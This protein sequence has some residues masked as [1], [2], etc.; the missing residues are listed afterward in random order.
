[1]RNRLGILYI[2]IN[3]GMLDENEEISLA[4]A[5][6]NHWD[7]I[8]ELI[9]NPQTSKLVYVSDERIELQ[10]FPIRTGSSLN[11]GY[12]LP[13][14]DGNIDSSILAK[15][16]ITKNVKLKVVVTEY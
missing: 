6:A 4:T 14:D 12:T 9:K 15:Y 7:A 13:D 11:L 3:N 2:K 8:V 16:T 5:Q 1:M 10:G